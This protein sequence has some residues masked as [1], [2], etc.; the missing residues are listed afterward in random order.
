MI[1]T[2]D[3]ETGLERDLNAAGYNKVFLWAICPI[4]NNKLLA[5]A[6]AAPT[7]EK[8][9]Y[10][11]KYIDSRIIY[12]NSDIGY[13][14]KALFSTTRKQ[15]QT[16]V[17]FHNLSYDGEFILDYLF[18]DGWRHID[19][20]RKLK[21]K[22][23]RTLITNLKVWY[24]IELCYND[25][26]ITIKD[27]Y[28]IL[29]QSEDNIIKSFKINEIYGVKKVNVDFE[30]L[31][32]LYTFKW[33][34]ALSIEKE[35]VVND[36]LG[37]ALALRHFKLNS[38]EQTYTTRDT[39]AS[40]AFE[41]LK[42]SSFPGNEKTSFEIK[43]QSHYPKLVNPYDKK[44]NLENAI[45]DF[46]DLLRS[47]YCGGYCY[48]NPIHASKTLE[49]VVSYD[50]NSKYPTHMNKELFPYGIAYTE[51]ELN[52]IDKN[53]FVYIIQLENV[54]ASI[55]PGWIPWIQNRGFDWHGVKMESEIETDLMVFVQPLYE[56]FLESYDILNEPVSRK[57]YFKA[58]RGRFSG[59]VKR[60]YEIK[61]HSD[62]NPVLK[63]FAK[64]QLNS[65]YGKFAQRTKRK[66]KI[67][68]W[69]DEIGQVA[70]KTV[71][72][73]RK[74]KQRYY[75]PVGMFITGYARVDIIRKAHSFGN[76]FVYCDTDS[77][78]LIGSYTKDELKEH[79]IK[80]DKNKLGY[81]KL[82]KQYSK[83]R[84]LHAKCYAGIMDGKLDI[85]VAGFNCAS[86]ED[87]NKVTLDDI[88]VGSKLPPKKGRRK[89]K[90]GCCLVKVPFEIKKLSK[91]ENIE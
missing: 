46:E 88:Y 9:E 39:A 73:E 57:F 49:N 42:K 51:D 80:V 67:P 37:M 59:H 17:Y 68:Y 26:I 10:I 15:K 62:D 47:G 53:D 18:K 79:D 23:F 2:A 77:L 56:L 91:D 11:N 3:F 89:C 81:W 75:L 36:V 14:F 25:H 33:R 78:H 87:Y 16:T 30:S 58:E 65:S 27:S 5:R 41:S 55:K 76:R 54:R 83:A 13:F 71:N 82:D 40:C 28:K 50:Q 70:Y 35:R 64:I 1:Y 32:P 6:K 72:Q 69:D 86:D 85:H 61:S 60:W 19:D 22:Q 45:I 34:K 7:D 90:G 20:D 44:E 21:H 4:E 66:R 48:V 29:G 38:T 43:F 74:E 31:P 63:F 84:Y 12:E 24:I 52:G 8:S